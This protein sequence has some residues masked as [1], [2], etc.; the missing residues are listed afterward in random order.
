M[1]NISAD[2]RNRLHKTVQSK[3]TNSDPRLTAIIYRED[4][5]FTDKT[6][7]DEI[8]ILSGLSSPFQIATRHSQK[9]VNCDKI[10]AADA[11]GIKSTGLN[12]MFSGGAFVWDTRLEITNASETAVAFNGKTI[13]AD[14]F[15]EFLTEREPYAF[16]ITGGN[17]YCK[18]LAAGINTTEGAIQVASNCTH[19]TSVHSAGG[20]H[21][22]GLI[23]LYTRGSAIYYRQFLNNEWGAE[24]AVS[25]LPVATGFSSIASSRAIDGRIVIQ[26]TTLA[27]KSYE[28][29]SVSGSEVF[30]WGGYRRL[31]ADSNTDYS[32]GFIGYQD[33]VVQSLFP[34]VENGES[35]LI[36]QKAESLP[37]D[38]SN[39]PWSINALF[40]TY[41]LPER[42]D[43]VLVAPFTNN[44]VFFCIKTA[45]GNTGLRLFRYSPF[46]VISNLIDTGTWYSQNDN[47]IEQCTLSIMN[48][49]D[50]CIR[51]KSTLY[52]PGMH[53]SISVSMGDSEPL[54]IGT[55]Y[56]DEVDYSE[57]E[58]F[59]SISGRNRTG[60]QLSE[61]TF[62]SHRTWSGL[63]HEIEGGMLE[64]AG[65]TDYECQVSSVRTV[66]IVPN[67]HRTIKDG[68]ERM[69]AYGTRIM[70]ETPNGKIVIGEPAWI[71][72][73]WFENGTYQFEAEKEVFSRNTRLNADAAYY[74]VCVF[75]PDEVL[76]DVYLDIPHYNNWNIPSSKIY[77]EAKPE[78]AS[79]QAELDAKANELALRMQ[80]VGITETFDSPFRP[81][82]L[83][84]DIA[85]IYY[86][87]TARTS[88]LGLITDVTHTFGK[89]GF[90]TQFTVDSG[91]AVVDGVSYSQGVYGFTRQ[92]RMMDYV[93]GW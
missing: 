36:S 22:Y 10:Y 48:T 66:I 23:V 26:F 53:I 40:E 52:Q 15:L 47:S 44:E 73:N 6:F 34:E 24:T 85:E 14:G 63:M 32:G 37:I 16:W 8:D 9:G 4:T 60:Y 81:Y 41:T 12:R 78:G 3:A 11:E 30:S 5:Y 59:I 55:A 27:H 65:V 92:Q 51:A 19:V 90:S 91:G 88:V 93:K 71:K 7:T 1:R 56:I 28:M 46:K 86:T 13:T 38:V 31:S 33:G 84:G 82:L 83:V 58:Q 62:G 76:T 39:T 87:S 57:R 64:L 80:N 2:L 77:Y 45:G 69:L 72:A 42:V 68:V 50:E 21:D 18:K 74:Q 70:H 35:I 49:G 17:L 29:Y 54:G 67:D 25:G 61:T 43:G 75:D 79:T 89:Q 20:S